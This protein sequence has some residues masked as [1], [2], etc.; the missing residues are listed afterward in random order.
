VTERIL[1]RSDWLWPAVAALAACVTA[2]ALSL[3]AYWFSPGVAAVLLP[4]GAVL[5]LIL[6]QPMAG[7]YAG[8]LCAPLEYLDLGVGGGI[9][10]LTAGE[11]VLLVTAASVLLCALSGGLGVLRMSLAHGAFAVLIG[12]ASLG[13]AFAPDTLVVFKIALMWS[14][15]LVLS[16][17][18]LSVTPG[19]LRWLLM[20]IALS[21]AVLALIAIAKGGTIELQEG[22]AFATNRAQA[23]FAHPAVLAFFLQLALPCAL[24]LSLTAGRWQRAPML[25]A[26]GLILTALMLTLTRGAIIGAGVSIAVLLWLPRFRL[27]AVLLLVA[28]VAFS[29]ANLNPILNSPQA[30]VVATRLGTILGHERQTNP[31]LRIYRGAP[32]MVID[33]PLFGIGAGNF[34]IVS[35]LYGLRDLGGDTFEHAHNVPLSIAVET[36]LLGLAAFFVFA[37]ALARAAIRILRSRDGPEFPLAIAPLAALSGLVATSM[38]DYP[39]RTNLIMA[40]IML[41]AGAMIAYSRRADG[42]SVGAETPMSSSHT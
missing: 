14:A 36:G 15:I 6:V 1:M 21:G 3:A 4:G 37:A 13:L 2:A 23:S 32:A 40:V 24:C 17:Y 42:S 41:E 31:R 11:A 38:T 26:A 10:E 8:V 16:L 9:I 35:P 12:I 39:L 27:L 25:I 34:P 33:H 19:Q 7:I 18:M 22:G 29:A 5:V 20:A 28:L 30:S